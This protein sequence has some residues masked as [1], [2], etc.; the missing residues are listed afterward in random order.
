MVRNYVKKGRKPLYSADTIKTAVEELL[1]SV[2]ENS[3]PSQIWNLDETSFC[4]DPSETKVVAPTGF[5][6]HRATARPGKKNITVSM[7]CNAA[8]QK[9]KKATPLIVFRGKHVWYSWM[10]ASNEEFTGITYAATKNGWMELDTFR[11]YLEKSCLKFIGDKRPTLLIYDGHSSHID[12]QLVQKACEENVII[13]KLAPHTS[14]IL[15]PLDLCVFRSLKQRWD[16][17]LIKW[18]RQNYGQ[19]LSKRV[20]S[21]LISK[22]WTETDSTIIRNGFKTAG[23]VPFNHQIISK[24]VFEPQ[25]YQRWIIHCQKAE[26]NRTGILQIPLQ[27]AN[28]LISTTNEDRDDLSVAKNAQN[29]LEEENPQDT[30]PYTRKFEDMLLETI[31]QKLSTSMK[32]QRVCLGAEAIDR[33]KQ[34]VKNKKS[35]RKDTKPANKKS[36]D[37]KKPKPRKVLIDETDEEPDEIFEPGESDIENELETQ[38]QEIN[39]MECINRYILA[40]KAENWVLV[41]NASKRTVKYLLCWPNYGYHC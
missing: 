2:S 6:V 16:Q 11:N 29:D 27:D 15:Q 37:K 14:H 28:A 32:R 23:I 26:E 13:L 1:K 35:K 39:F 4:L 33:V 38:E 21:T 22:I 3:N 5:P 19:K 20:F 9:S 40:I 25:L 17:Q 24:D 18:Q 10:A 31:K 8:G 34:S 36:K 7:A 12:L 41:M 30:L